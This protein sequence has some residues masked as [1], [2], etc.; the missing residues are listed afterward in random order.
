[1]KTILKDSLFENK[2][3][4][5]DF[6]NE[7]VKKFNPKD[8]GCLDM[9]ASGEFLCMAIKDSNEAREF[10]S[11][12]IVDIDSFKEKEKESYITKPDEISF[13]LLCETYSEHFK[14]VAVMWSET[15]QCFK[16]SSEYDLL[17]DNPE[18]FE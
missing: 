18:Y 6:L 15:Y 9:Y 16:C 5:V 4:C 17:V 3:V 11:K 1:M 12:F 13:S 10:L 7:I 8:S 2:T 14:Q